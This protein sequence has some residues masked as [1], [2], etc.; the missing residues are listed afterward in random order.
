[1]KR[2]LR[3]R[4][5]RRVIVTLKS[6]ESFGGVLYEADTEAIVLRNAQAIGMGEK[7]SNL[8]VDGEVL[9]LRADVSFLQLP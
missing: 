8:A 2:L 7:Q 4:L 1:M 5:R 9:L 6:G 3:Q